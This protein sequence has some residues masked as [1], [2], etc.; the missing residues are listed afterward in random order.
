LF[1]VLFILVQHIL[2][3][4]DAEALEIV[5]R[6]ITSISESARGS[7]HELCGVDEGK[8]MLGR[9]EKE[10]VNKEQKRQH[11]LESELQDFEE[12]WVLEKKRQTPAVGRVRI[13]RLDIPAGH[14]YQEG[15]NT[16]KPPGTSVWRDNDVVEG[17]WAGHCPPYARCSSTIA[18]AKSDRGALIGVLRM[19][20]K[21]HLKLTARTLQECPIKGLFT[22]G[23]A[24]E[25]VA[26]LAV[27]PPVELVG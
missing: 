8:Q 9:D 15:A 13:V 20:W 19:L 23:G 3:C 25:A 4:T 27:A 16:L 5:Q 6:R 26:P 2:K 24:L 14:I 1:R 22:E 11:E 10:L 7:Q 18:V 17:G 21:Q 12:D